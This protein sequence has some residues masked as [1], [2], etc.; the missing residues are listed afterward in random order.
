M[1]LITLSCLFSCS[2]SFHFPK[3]DSVLCSQM[4]YVY[5]HRLHFLL[6]RMCFESILEEDER[7]FGDL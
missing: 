7:R 1:M 6:I 4:C 5:S 2:G 3:P